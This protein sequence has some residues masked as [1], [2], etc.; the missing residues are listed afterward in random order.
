MKWE[1]INTQICSIARTLSIVGDRWTLLII[2]DIFMGLRR[3]SEIQSS[4]EI[5]KH[6]LSDRLHKLQQG[7]II[8]KR[9][10][11]PSGKRFEYFLT[12]KGLDLYPV[13]IGLVQWGDRW[14]SGQYGEPVRY[15]H[16]VCG[17]L[18]R[19][20]YCCDQCGVPLHPSEIENCPGPA[21]KKLADET[22]FANLP[23]RVKKLLGSTDS[24]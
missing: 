10:V 20:H 17:E 9:T 5:T 19:P 24:R 22:Q 16:K 4:L 23:L 2:R 18:M 3:F 8:E 13:L 15:R 12:E 14:E 11:D 6:R 21:V 1:E 7:G